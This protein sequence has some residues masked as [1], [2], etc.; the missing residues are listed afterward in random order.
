VC[1]SITKLL[2]ATFIKVLSSE[3][4]KEDKDTT[5]RAAH[6][7]LGTLDFFSKIT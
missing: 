7:I 1:R 6:P 3:I 4:M 5:I 2:I